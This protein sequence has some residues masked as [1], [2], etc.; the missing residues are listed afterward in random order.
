[1]N[2]QPVPEETKEK[3]GDEHDP[4]TNDATEKITAPCPLIAFY[5]TKDSATDK[6][7]AKDKEQ[8]DGLVARACKRIKDGEWD[9]I[10]RDVR[11]VDEEEIAPMLE[12]HEKGR[13]S[14]QKIEVY[15]GPRCG[16]LNR[17][18]SRGGRAHVGQALKR[19]LW[20]PRGLNLEG[21]LIP[22]HRK[23]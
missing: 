19:N 16:E 8:N 7:A 5:G 21:E 11:I 20:F 2:S 6:V 12:E 13:Q 14:T 10:S 15:R 9:A 3:G 23:S 17:A 18:G 1:M 4:K 22:S